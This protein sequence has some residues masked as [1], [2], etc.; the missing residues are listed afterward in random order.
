MTQSGIQQFVK[1]ILLG[2][3]MLG[4]SACAY[5]GGSYGDG[6]VNGAG[7]AC[8][9]YAPFDDYYACDN[10]YGYANIGF[11]GGWYDS[12][13]YPGYGIYIFDRRGS[14]YAMKRHHRYHWAR[15][16]AKF[17]SRRGGY[18]GIGR[19]GRN[20]TPEQ[21][22]ERRERIRNLTP[23]Q[24]AERRER[25][26]ERRAE[27]NSGN[28]ATTGRAALRDGAIRGQRRGEARQARRGNRQ[29]NGVRSERRT[30]PAA[31]QQRGQQTRPAARSAPRQ[32]TRARPAMRS[33]RSE[34]S[35][36]NINDD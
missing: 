7:Y 3:A 2:G 15:Q 35:R 23:E 17:G 13:Y 28:R 21:R 27:R 31:T 9:P 19:G 1:P 5:G 22:A 30:R 12:F 16:R 29:G 10:G 25:R 34:T 26:A 36:R 11:G 4:L 32:A 24:R 6:Y 33:P 18:D 14:R 8:D 20:L